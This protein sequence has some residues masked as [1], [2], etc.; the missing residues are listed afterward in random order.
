MCE[1][2]NAWAWGMYACEC[3]RLLYEKFY[4]VSEVLKMFNTTRKISSL[5]DSAN[6]PRAKRTLNVHNNQQTLKD[7]LINKFHRLN[8]KPQNY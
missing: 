1:S 2:V 7:S 5:S 3:V 6:L 4:S 8:L